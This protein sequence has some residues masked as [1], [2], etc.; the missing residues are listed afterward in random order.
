M[1]CAEK[2]QYY[3]HH[4]MMLRAIGGELWTLWSILFLYFNSQMDINWI[5]YRYLEKSWPSASQYLALLGIGIL[6]WAIGILIFGVPKGKLYD[7]VYT[8]MAI[9][10]IGGEVCGILLKLFKLP[11]IIGMIGFGMFYQYLGQ[12]NFDGYENLEKFIKYEID[13]FIQIFAVDK[14]NFRRFDL[15]FSNYTFRDVALVNVLLV[16]GMLMEFNA[17]V[18]K[19]WVALRLS[20]VTTMGET[21][22]IAGMSMLV[23]KMPFIWS[24]MLG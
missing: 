4:Q 19:F 22:I 2:I 6:I 1:R 12:A 10:F 21:L 15:K 23:L 16:T 9:L 3:H 20:I 8:R 5:S 13:L 24:F 17:L 7:I 18:E 11:D 14:S